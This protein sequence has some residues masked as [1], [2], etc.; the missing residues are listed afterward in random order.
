MIP[1]AYSFVPA[2]L[3]INFLALIGRYC[4]A[5]KQLFETSWKGGM[6]NEEFDG[7]YNMFYELNEILRLLSTCFGAFLLA[8]IAIQ[9]IISIQLVYNLFLTFNGL[10]EF[11]ITTLIPTFA[12]L[13]IQFSVLMTFITGCEKV[14]CEQ[15][16]FSSTLC[17]ST[18]AD[19]ESFKNVRKNI[20]PEKFLRFLFQLTLL[21]LL[22][23]QT[24][25]EFK[26]GKLF[27]INYQLTTMFFSA[28]IS[29][30]IV[31]IQFHLQN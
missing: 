16:C 3:F 22:M 5:M 20:F 2:F 9:F 7:L 6:M 21:Q 13:F 24:K 18:V 19:K 4:T 28:I 26:A 1:L 30:L 23:V 11:S 29:Y 14:S 15:S 27:P 8:S 31:I 10:I 12:W 25:P 17:Q